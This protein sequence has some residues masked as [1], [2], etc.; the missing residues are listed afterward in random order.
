MTRYLAVALLVFLV[1]AGIAAPLA[2]QDA[3]A[4][5]AELAK[6]TG[7]NKDDW[8]PAAFA[9][10]QKGMTCAQVKAQIPSIGACGATV[11]AK[12][13]GSPVLDGYE[14][15]FRDDK[16]YSATLLFKRSLDKA[17]F[18]QASIEVFEAKWGK[19][20]ADKRDADLLTW[21]GPGSGMTQRMFLVDQWQVAVDLP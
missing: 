3:A 18:K 11:E 5:K 13:E 6:V 4:L 9:K 1:G 15:R 14:F 2:A 10:L 8:R 17:A 12:A 16:L 20:K 21:V 19:Q 7:T